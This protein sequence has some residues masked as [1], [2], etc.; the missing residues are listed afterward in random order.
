MT[1]LLV[2]GSSGWLSGFMFIGNSLNISDDE[3]CASCKQ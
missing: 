3:P 2:I 1:A